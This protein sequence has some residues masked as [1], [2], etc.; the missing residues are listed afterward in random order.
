MPDD[1]LALLDELLGQDGRLIVVSN[2]GPVTFQLDADAPSRLTAA[3]GSGGL[4][5]ALAELGRHAP[6]T[7]VSAAMTEA[8]ALAA[9]AIATWNPTAARQNGGRRRAGDL[10]LEVVHRTHD[11]L[12][13]LLPGQNLRLR[14]TTLPPGVFEPY[15][16][17][18]ANPFLW[19]LQHQMFAPAY[20]PNIDASLL[21]AWRTGYRPANECLADAAVEAVSAT[22]RGEDR[23]RPVILLQDYHLYLA[24]ARIRERLPEA[25]ILHFNHI[26][27]PAESVWQ[28]LPQRLRRAICEGLLACDIVGFQT[29]RYTSH[30]LD[31]VAKASCATLAST[32]PA[33]PSAGT[34]AVSGRG[35]IR[36]RSI[37]TGCSDLRTRKPSKSA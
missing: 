33:E 29:D 19:F 5:T 25:T 22:I 10:S 26:P 9:P 8:D 3:R 23:R 1:R 20:G 21:D 35:A 28:L 2:R 31:T 12:D 17:V 34:T 18:I 7:W 14:V 13:E 24:A 16:R 32:R 11:L 30:F 4:V 27:W 36:S 37:P 6:V 15:Y